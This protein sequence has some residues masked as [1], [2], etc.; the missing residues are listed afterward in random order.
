MAKLAENKT[1]ARTLIDDIDHESTIDQLYEGLVIADKEGRFL[2]CSRIARSVLSIGTEEE[3]VHSWSQ[4]DGWHKADGL[5]PY[6]YEELP[7]T[8]AAAGQS[9]PETEVFVRNGRCPDG[10]W[11]AVQ[12]NPLMNKAGEIH[13]SVV[14]F[15]DI[16]Q[17]RQVDAQVRILTSAV[18]Q[19][20]D[21][22]IITDDKAFIEYVNPAFETTTGFTRE[23]ALGHTPMI[24]K[25]GAHDDAFY[26]KLWTTIISGKAFRA[27]IVNRKKNGEIFFAEQTITPMRDSTGRITHFVTVIKDVTDLRK[28]QEQQFQMSLARA[29]QQQFYRAPAPKVKGF[30]LAGAAF[31]ADAT[32]GDY[33]DFVALPG[34]CIGIATGD[35]SGHGLSSALLMAELRAYLRAFAQKSSDIGE[36]LTLTNGALISDLEQGTYA[37]L[38]FCCLHPDTRTIQ[39][40][41]AGHTPGFILDPNGAVRRTLDSID[42]PLG[43]LPGYKFGFSDQLTLEPGEILALLT[44]GITDAERPDQEQFGVERALAFIREHREESANEIAAKLFQAVRDF[45]DGMPQLDDITVVIC[46]ANV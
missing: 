44:D 28:M 8:V 26:A 29:V 33:F 10:I 16:T 7:S 38:F 43:F 6:P 36:I 18:E 2:I 34:D 23:E 31:P 32:G 4:A 37:T 25:S 20:A 39:Y 13:G 11:I 3:S 22:I 27:T 12:A 5:T 21:C 40:A 19:T 42:L 45:E 35:V 41:S 14:A 17:K 46:K 24:L 15:R 30:D 9:I 1:S